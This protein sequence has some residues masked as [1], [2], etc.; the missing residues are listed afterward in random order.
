M[1]TPNFLPSATEPRVATFHGTDHDSYL[2]TTAEFPLAVIRM[3]PSQLPDNMVQEYVVSV[4]PILDGLPGASMTLSGSETATAALALIA[5]TTPALNEDDLLPL[6]PEEGGE[7]STPPLMS[8][9]A[10]F[11]LDSSVI[12]TSPVSAGSGFVDPRIASP[13]DEIRNHD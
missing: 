2:I 9:D 7:G 6:N 3:A 4:Q 5:N 12:A 8:F 11:D 10:V 1:P 13:S